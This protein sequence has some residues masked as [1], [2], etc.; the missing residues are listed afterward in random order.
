MWRCTSS[1]QGTDAIRE[2][3]RSALATRPTIDLRTL[4]VNRA[5]ELAML[6]GKWT[7][8]ET[9]AVGVESQRQ[10]RNTEVVR[11]QADGRW[12]FVIDNPLMP[13]D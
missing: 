4:R 3:Y 2:A 6:H 11:L 7:L 1:A 8:R 10:G 5:G 12:L 9:G 13:E